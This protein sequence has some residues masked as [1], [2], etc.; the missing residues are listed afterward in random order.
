VNTPRLDAFA[1]QAHVFDNAYMG[2][3][4]TVPNRRDRLFD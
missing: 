4:P 2:S 1:G 3:F